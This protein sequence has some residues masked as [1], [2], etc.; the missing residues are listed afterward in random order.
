MLVIVNLAAAY[1]IAFADPRT[2]ID[3]LAPFR[4]ERPMRILWRSVSFS[5]AG[6]TAH[7][8]TPV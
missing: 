4:A 3:H 7:P 2:E 1:A 5:L 6:W 8:I